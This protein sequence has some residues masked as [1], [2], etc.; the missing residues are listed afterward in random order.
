[1]IILKIKPLSV[2]QVRQWKR[3]KT[4]LYDKYEQIIKLMLKSINIPN[5]KL[6]IDY[7]FW[8]SNQ[9]SDID[10]P[11]KPLQDILC[12]KYKFDDSRIYEITVQKQ[13]VKK[14][15]DFIWFFI[16]WIE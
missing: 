2:N 15:E 6:R 4:K 3:Y 7:V 9:R 1:M 10:N 16:K 5:W 13:I 8:F 12:K 11:I 14:W